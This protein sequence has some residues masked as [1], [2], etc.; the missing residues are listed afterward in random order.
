[1]IQHMKAL[2]AGTNSFLRDDYREVVQL[3]PVL[4]EVAPSS[5]GSAD[6]VPTATPGG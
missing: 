5:L 4:L 6:Q 1:M 2:L 3:T